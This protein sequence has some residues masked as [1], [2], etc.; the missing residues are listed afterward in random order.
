MRLASFACLF[1]GLPVDGDAIE[2]E[3]DPDS[4]AV[5]GGK[6]VLIDGKTSEE[7]FREVWVTNA[8]ATRVDFE[9]ELYRLT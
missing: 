8:D 6:Q 2:L 9:N 5:S 7:Y 1:A 4:T 3:F